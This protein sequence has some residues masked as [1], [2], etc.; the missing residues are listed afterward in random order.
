MV[1]EKSARDRVKVWTSRLQSG[2]QSDLVPADQ[3]YC[4]DAWSTVR[5]GVNEYHLG[6]APSLW[7]ASAG[8]GLISV[9]ERLHSYSA[10]FSPRQHDSVCV[11]GDKGDDA[12]W[13]KGLCDWAKQVKREPCSIEA[14][15]KRN[16][17][18]PLLIAASPDYL[19][20]I[21]SDVEAAC[22]RLIDP[23]LL[24]IVSAGSSKKG[25]LAEHFL[26]CDARLE[27]R[28]GGARISLNSRI[29]RHILETTD[30]DHM[31]CGLLKK[32]FKI[33][34]GLQPEH[35]TFNRPK[36]TDQKVAKFVA[37]NL[38]VH[39]DSTH[40]ALLREFRASN[41]ACEQKRFR[42]IFGTVKRALLE[43]S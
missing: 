18:T 9:H 37:Y 27:H 31:R 3:L 22:A 11:R 32:R 20:A 5:S 23:D 12:I 34:L 42:Q 10:T 17:S 15:A 13:W 30:P 21:I 16:P 35:R 28:F 40:S 2:A 38:R 25:A 39:P 43:S 36:V 4:G 33:L 14:L 41:Q 24:V 7:V 1:V 19:S 8:Y 29:V 26:P 6:A